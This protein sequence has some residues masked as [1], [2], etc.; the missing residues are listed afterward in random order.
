MYLAGTMKQFACPA[1]PFYLMI[2][3][4]RAAQRAG[5]AQDNASAVIP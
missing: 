1:G 5:K 3:L 4:V 2:N